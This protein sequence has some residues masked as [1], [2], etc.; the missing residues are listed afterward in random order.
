MCYAAFT[1]FITTFTDITSR[2]GTCNAVNHVKMM[3]YVIIKQANSL[4]GF[5]LTFK[6]YIF[7]MLSSENYNSVL[8]EILLKPF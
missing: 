2:K 3:L 1:P 6:Y 8:F 5:H 4:F 7:K